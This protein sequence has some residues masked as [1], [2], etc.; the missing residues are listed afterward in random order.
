VQR[1]RPARRRR[2]RGR[3]R[4]PVRPRRSPRP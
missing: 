1:L 4:A 2:Q 3:M